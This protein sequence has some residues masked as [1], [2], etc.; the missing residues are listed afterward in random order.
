M[1]SGGHSKISCN[2]AGGSHW[3][4]V[5]LDQFRS[6]TALYRRA[7]ADLAYARMRYPGSSAVK[8]LE[9]LVA[10]THSVVYQARWGNVN[11]LVAVPGCAPGPSIHARRPLG[12]FCSP[13]CI[14]WFAAVVGLLAVVRPAAV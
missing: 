7:V 6:G 14:F 13:W 2:S 5:P 1:R 11:R 4:R 12:R 3:S 8:E 9:R 10:R